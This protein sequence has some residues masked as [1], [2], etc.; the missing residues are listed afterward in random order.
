MAETGTFTLNNKE[1]SVPTGLFINNE[2]VPSVSGKKFTTVYPAT[3]KPIID[4]YEAD[5]DD[6]EKAVDAAEHAFKTVWKKTSGS[7]RGRLMYKL[8]DLMERDLQLL[9]ELEALDNGKA[10][11]VASST[12]L[13]AAIGHIRYFAGWADKIQGKSINLGENFAGQIQIDP[14][15]V[16]GQII[17]WNFPLLMLA[18]KW[19]PALA[20][21]NT[22]VMK[23][24][25]KTPLSALKV[26]EL[27]VE[28]GFPAGVINVLSGF[29]PTAGQA[30]AEHPRIKK[31]AF[32]GSTGVGRK[33]M[34]AAAQSNLKKVSLELGGKSPNIIFPDADIDAAIRWASIGIF[35]NHG[36]CCCAGSRLFI[37][38]DIY[39]EFIEKFKA[40][41]ATIK[42]GDPLQPETG[43][44]P[45]VDNLQF[46]RVL[47]YIQKGKDE[48]ATVVFGGER[49]G[50]EGYFVPPT[51]FSNVT[52]D[53][54]I[55]KEEIFGPVV[56]ALK[57][58]TEEEVI[59]RANN[60][61]YGL[62]AA[63]HTNDLKLANRVSRA[64]EA[65]TVWVNCYNMFFNQMPFGGYK[66][67]GI[68]RENSEYA[69]LEYSQV[70]SVTISLQ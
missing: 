35:F 27:A 46:E 54:T 65:G 41:A 9:A 61:E 30:I 6:V 47:S 25:E 16:V 17:P 21:G 44:G 60:T 14:F 28:A 55:V 5:K 42:I 13:P 51:L 57:F 68:G 43:H 49:H 18:W 69:L 53:M 2:F 36:Q 11:S 10:V 8:A 45:L 12:D 58:K 22:I 4:L 23:T 38:E 63:V 39:D 32:T 40:H 15:G 34:V 29:G 3:G 62:A 70:K 19:G 67:S 20:C 37:H 7:E 26:C 59:E 52:D 50:T 56:C 48:G 64:L 1:Y 66:T 24:S 31:V 33:I